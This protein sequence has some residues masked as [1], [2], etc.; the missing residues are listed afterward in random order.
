[1]S[2]SI[3]M[4]LKIIQIDHCNSGFILHLFDLFFKKTPIIYPGQYIRI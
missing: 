1:M 4:E 2:I 3:V